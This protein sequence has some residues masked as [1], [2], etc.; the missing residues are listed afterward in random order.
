MIA[1]LGQRRRDGVGLARAGR[2]QQAAP[3]G[4]Q[5]PEAQRDPER[6]L[7]RMTQ[8]LAEAEASKA[9]AEARVQALRAEAAAMCRL[10][11]PA[12]LPGPP[13]GR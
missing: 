5:Y 10:P 3:R 13:A 7:S 9:A 11:D 2:Q 6:E 1:R 8:R 4:A 12:A